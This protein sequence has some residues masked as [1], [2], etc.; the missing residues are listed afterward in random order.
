[1]KKILSLLT[2][3]MVAFQLLAAPIDAATARAKAQQYLIKTLY[4]GKSMVPAAVRPTLIMTEYGDV[5]KSTPA[6]YIFN[7]STTFLIISGDDRAEEVLAYG[8]KPLNLDRMPKNMK[9]WLD[10]YKRQID[11]LHSN[12]TIKVEKPTK[13]RSPLIKSGETIQPLLTAMWDQEAPYWN[14]CKFSYN[15]SNYQCYTGCPATSAAMVMYYWKYPSTPVDPIPSYTGLLDIGYWTTVEYTYPALSGTTFDWDNMQDTYSTYTTAQAN[16]VATLMRY[17]GQA[18]HMKYGTPAAGGSGINNKDTQNI[19]DMFIL[20]GYDEVTCRLVLKDN[21]SEDNWAD[22]LQTELAEGRPVVYTAV[23]NTAGGHAFNVDGYDS[24]TN[25]YHVNWGWSGEGNNWFSM[26]AFKDG[27]DT[28]DQVQK[29]IIGIQPS[30]PHT[31]ITATPN[32]LNFNTTS[33]LES[34]TSTFTVTGVNLEDDITVT[35]TDAKGAFSIDTESISIEEATNGKTVTVTF[36]PQQAGSMSGTITLQSANANDVTIALTGYATKG[37]LPAPVLS[38]AQNLT[39]NSFTAAWTHPVNT[40]IS[41]NL[42][43]S[44]MN[45]VIVANINNIAEQNYTVTGLT[46]GTTYIY[47][48]KAMPENTNQYNPS[49]WSNRISVTLPDLPEFEDGDINCDGVVDV[50][51]V[52]III[53]I[54]LG[55]DHAENYSSKTDLNNDGTVDVGDVNIIIN[56]ILGADHAVQHH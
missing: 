20:F 13:F 14:M 1:M 55:A 23:S 8:D 11:Y 43:V 21:Y 18:E 36:A 37:T 49:G 16:A 27:P 34:K 10:G 33:T 39:P 44:T 12:P 3:V 29:M 15:G 47:A 22:L 26:N 30:V 6:Y 24:S 5:N 51:D 4:A 17:V 52:N 45:G 48:V 50:G 38:E 28:F 53:N 56:I 40:G 41:Y 46:A 2:V 42:S 25:K 32:T 19:A 7:T 35:L 54:I 9:A 31:I